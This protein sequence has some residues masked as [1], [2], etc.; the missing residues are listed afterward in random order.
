VAAGILL[1]GSASYLDRI[2]APGPKPEG[3]AS[4]G[5][6]LWLADFDTNRIYRID[7][8]HPETVVS[9]PAPGAGPEGLAWDG[10]HLWAGSWYARKIYRLAVSDTALT[11]VRSFDPPS[12]ARP[13]GLAWD[14]TQLWHT[15][16]NPK[17]LHR[18]DPMTGEVLFTRAIPGDPALYPAGSGVYG[19]EDLAWDG[20]GLWITDWYGGKVFRL[21][22][23]TLAIT[24]T[25]PSGGRRSVGLAFHQGF[26][27]NGDTEE[28]ALFRLDVTPVEPMSWGR[29][30]RGREF[31]REP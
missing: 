12:G 6:S 19:P 24:H 5:T 1:L 14:G 31:F 21:D 13:V 8:L 9:F 27:W 11:V 28:A 29:V 10:T 25:V 16:W 2:P 30:K 4:D 3:L 22:P 7:P 18:L 23:Q 26:L 15:T 20:T 17:A